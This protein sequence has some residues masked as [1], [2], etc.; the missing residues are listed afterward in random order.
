MA[1]QPFTPGRQPDFPG[2]VSSAS[3]EFDVAPLDGEGATYLR[4]GGLQVLKPGQGI[5]MGGHHLGMLNY[6]VQGR[7]VLEFQSQQLEIEQDMV[8]WTFANTPAQLTAD[9]V[10][11][12]E[13]YCIALWNGEAQAQ[14]QQC[15]QSAAGASRLRD[16]V[17]VSAV[18]QSLME[19]GQAMSEHRLACCELL[20]KLLIKRID[21]SLQM[22]REG[23]LLARQTFRR[24]REYIE[25]RFMTIANLREVAVACDVTV[26]YLCRLF[27]QFLSKYSPYEYLTWLK[28]IRAESLL[29]RPDMSV[30]DV[31]QAVGYKDA[32][33][34]TRNFKAQ[35]GRSP[36]QY[37]N[38][39]SGGDPSEAVVEDA[40]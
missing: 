36:S 35:F 24:C 27:D 39:S 37:R 31:A 12:M 29:L 18:M 4:W 25:R 14:M 3:Y 13:N 20:A 11:G 9:G 28:M 1:D 21:V 17:R 38:N 8:F 2:D 6:C 10:L 23:S 40:G 33:L 26:P 16:P 30:R 7:G 19:E 32:R 5:G 15:F 34:F 22:P